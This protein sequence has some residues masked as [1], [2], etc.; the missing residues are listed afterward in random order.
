[1]SHSHEFLEEREAA[2]GLRVSIRFHEPDGSYRDLLGH[3]RA[4]NEVEKRDGTRVVF[5]PALIAYFKVV[6]ESPFSTN[7]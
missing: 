7:V 3:L 1:M 2:L 4:L 6:P 5:D